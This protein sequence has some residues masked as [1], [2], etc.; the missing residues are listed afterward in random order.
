MFTRLAWLVEIA[1][2]LCNQVLIYADTGYALRDYSL[3]VV[4]HRTL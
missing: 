1:F 4:T 2:A 3:D